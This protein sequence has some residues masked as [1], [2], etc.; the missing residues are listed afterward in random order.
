MAVPKYNE[1]FPD[2]ME[3]LSDGNEHAVQEVRDYLAGIFNLSDE[4]MR[5]KTPSGENLFFNRVDWAK[6]YL[7]KAGLIANPE[8][9]VV[10]IT[11][12][13]KKVLDD[14]TEL[15]LDFVKDLMI[16][17]GEYPTKSVTRF[18]QVK[19]MKTRT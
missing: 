17:N 3:F 13:G 5:A 8:L 15:T 19:R 4:D 12:F 9:A 10:V 11:P 2:F 1:F 14:K 6:L 18:S 16:K 7:K